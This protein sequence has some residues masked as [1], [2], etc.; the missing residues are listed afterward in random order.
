MIHIN[1]FIDKIKMLESRQA[2]EL[3]LTMREAKDLHG[4]ITK[5]LLVLQTLQTAEP[6]DESDGQIEITGGGFTD[7]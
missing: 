2:K 5:L 3:T 7:K 4:D 1:R 6:E